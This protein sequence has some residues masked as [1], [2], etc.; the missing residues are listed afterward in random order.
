MKCSETTKTL[1]GTMTQEGWIAVLKLAT[2]WSF[3][4]I[5][6]LAISELTEQSVEPV[7]KVLLARACSVPGWLRAGYNT[8]A[9]RPDVLSLEEAERIGYRTA[10]R[11]FHVREQILKVESAKNPYRYLGDTHIHDAPLGDAYSAIER[12]F[13]AELREVEAAYDVLEIPDSN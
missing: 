5:R 4:D 1:C 10:V 9:R 3:K 2:M 11:L 8:L 12:E 13:A 7:E 6:K